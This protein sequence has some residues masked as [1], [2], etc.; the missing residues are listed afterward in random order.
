MSVSSSVAVRRNEIS[1]SQGFGLRGGESCGGVK[2]AYLDSGRT[3]T[4]RAG[5]RRPI[6]VPL[7]TGLLRVP[8]LSGH[9]ALMPLFPLARLLA[10]G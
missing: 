3:E 10:S 7:L 4:G 9:S 5:L 8:V 2:E 1:S 6:S